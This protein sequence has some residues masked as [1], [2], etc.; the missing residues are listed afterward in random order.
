MA[1]SAPSRSMTALRSHEV[2]IDAS[3]PLRA[4]P[5][6]GH[7]RW[8]PEIPPILRVDP[9]DEVAL[10]T[11]DALDGQITA[12]STTED[13]AKV[14]LNVVHPLTG[15]VYVN[16]AE[17]GDILEVKIL[18]VEPASFGFTVQIP[19]FGFLR[20]QF[21]DP[22][23][24]RW[25]IA[26]GTAESADLPGVRIH[27][28]PFPGTIGLAPSRALMQAI[29]KREKELLD[30]GGM[31]LPP[32]PTDAVPS[33]SRLA[34][35]ALRTVPPRE[36][37]GNVDIKQL[38]AG[39]TMLIPVQV[40]GALFSVGDAHFAQGDGEICGTA[41]EMASVFHAQFFLRKGE[42]ARRK[43]QDVAY[44][45]DT[46][47]VAPE[48]AV[49]RRYYATTGLSVEKGGLNQSENAT[50]AARNAMLNM[51]DHLEERGY[52]RQQAYA[53][54][55]VAVDLKIS[56]VVDVPNFVVSAVLPLDIFV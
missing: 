24:V 48:L 8:H 47:A 11:R 56:E 22:F 30:R 31:V 3:K 35:E 52:S 41:I 15:P 13:V 10:E 18:E 17:P 4:E 34:A 50:L 51:V 28:A 32:D 6:T 21:P 49:P 33:D 46:Y 5:Q 36:T 43:R 16:G 7:N 19:G 26:G 42:A 2:R 40:D 38:C 23:I 20:D 25:R 27:G 9:G 45:R 12:Q 29:T 14:N 44:F 39:T 37:A 54:C 53:I 1:V 55:S